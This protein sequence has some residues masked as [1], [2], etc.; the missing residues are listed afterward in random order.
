MKGVTKLAL[1][2]VLS[3]AVL[4]VVVYCVGVAE[5]ARAVVQAGLPAFLSLGAIQAALLVAQ[6]TAWASLNRPI[7]HRIRFRTLLAATTVALAG[8][9][10]TPSTYLGGEPAKVLYAGRRTHLPYHQLAGTILLA[11][12]LEALSFVFV[13]ATATV[14][15]VAGYADILFSPPHVAVGLAVVLL[16]AGA[17]AAAAMLWLSLRRGWLPLTRLVALLG[18]LPGPAGRIGRLRGRCARME[19]QASEVFNNR[20]HRAVVPAMACL[21]GTHAVMFIKP[22]VFFGLGWA[23]PLGAARLSLLFL[24]SQVLLAVQLTPSGV[25]TLDGGLLAVVAL[26]GIPLSAPQCAAY[27][28]CMRFWDAAVIGVAAMLAGRFGVNLLADRRGG[29]KDG[30]IGTTGAAEAK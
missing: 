15:A 23:V 3:A 8:N 7:G 5:T 4:A 9:I 13:L 26:A 18:R 1:L 16:A 12:Y 27:L 20:E 17:L 6:A 24:A 19:R 2:G 30:P 22:L 10:L 25:G 14:A 29:T 28:L 11:K 21:L